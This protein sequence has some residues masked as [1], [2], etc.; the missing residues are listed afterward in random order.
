M[1]LADKEKL[2]AIRNG[3]P[4]EL[5]YWT[6]FTATPY[7]GTTYDEISGEDSDM[8]ILFVRADGSTVTIPLKVFE[9]V[10]VTSPTPNFAYSPATDDFHFSWTGGT[11]DVQEVILSGTCISDYQS[12]VSGN[13]HLLPAGTISSH[14]G[15]GATAIIKQESISTSSADSETQYAYTFRFLSWIDIYVQ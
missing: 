8:Q 4:T 5:S 13:D 11:L 10:D 1:R 14:G 6:D 2:I 7:Y 15:C 12:K 9:P 3:V